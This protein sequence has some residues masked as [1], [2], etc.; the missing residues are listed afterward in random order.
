MRSLQ[1][2]QTAKW[3]SPDSLSFAVNPCEG[4]FP[5]FQT[6]FGPRSHSDL[7]RSV[8]HALAIAVTN[9]AFRGYRT[10]K[11]SKMCTL[12]TSCGVTGS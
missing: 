3:G 2:L 5:G 6:P 11:L 10:G 4:W 12:Q 7:P 1:M 8:S 9:V